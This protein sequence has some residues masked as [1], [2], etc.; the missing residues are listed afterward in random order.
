MTPL[1]GRL[2]DIIG[3]RNANLTAL[4]LFFLGTA[5]CALAPSMNWLIVARMFS[6]MGDT[7]SSLT[8]VSRAKGQYWQ[9]EEEC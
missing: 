9:V 8:I 3:R 6:G 7:S 2:V 1:Y 5:L 4:C